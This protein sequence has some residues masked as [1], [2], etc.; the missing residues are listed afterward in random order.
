MVVAAMLLMAS[1]PFF[2]SLGQE[3]FAHLTAGKAPADIAPKIA[4]L[5]F[6]GGLLLLA[7]ILV[8]RTVQSFRILRRG[9]ATPAKITRTAPQQDGAWKV[10][11]SYRDRGGVAHEG[12]FFTDSDTW[13][14]GD[15]G[16]VRFDPE[17]PITS[18][19]S[20][21][22]APTRDARPLPPPSVG[23][24]LPSVSRWSAI[25]ALAP[26]GYLVHWFWTAIWRDGGATLYE[27]WQTALVLALV[28]A[29]TM[30]FAFWIIAFVV[31][32]GGL[33][34]MG[35]FAVVRRALRD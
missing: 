14:E 32:F 29:V 20:T 24:P 13:R 16:E 34:A 21:D 17:S 11:Y 26:A 9:L 28:F 7:G 33:F 3:V 18:T 6:T 10:T 4:G 27:P 5:I 23:K 25:L 35:I 30:A 1:L 8:Q 12:A 2:F 22:V 19:W 31:F 15:A